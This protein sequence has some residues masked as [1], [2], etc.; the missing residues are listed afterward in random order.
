MDINFKQK[1]LAKQV[2]CS[3]VGLH[4]GKKVNLTIKPA[5]MNHGIFSTV[6]RTD[7]KTIKINGKEYK[8]PKDWDQHYWTNSNRS[9]RDHGISSDWYHIL[10]CSWTCLLMLRWYQELEQ[11][12]R[13]LNYA[14]DY[15]DRLLTLQDSQGDHN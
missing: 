4:S 9:P 6:I 10:D 14:R 11:D 12:E 15:G 7:N 3:G 1:T 5:P 2:C 13:L 8:R